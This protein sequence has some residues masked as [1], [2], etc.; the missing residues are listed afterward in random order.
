MRES[1]QGS[2]RVT[3]RLPRLIAVGFQGFGNVGDEA[4]LCGL[5]RLLDGAA[6][7]DT[8]VAGTVGPVW[9]AKG[10]RRI[11]PWRLLPTPAA[12]RR[13]RRSDGLII[14]GGGLVNDYWPLVIPRYLAWVLAARLLGRPVVWAGIGVGPVRRRP[15][16]ILGGVAFALSS[17][18]IVRDRASEVA[19]H[20]LIPA[21]SVTMAADPAFAMRADPAA[22]RRGVGFIVRSP[23][24]GDESLLGALVEALASAAMALH[25]RGVPVDIL[26]MHPVEDSAISAAMEAALSEEARQ[27]VSVSQLPA[28]PH[29]AAMALDGYQTLVSMRLHGVIL[30]AVA[31][32][33]SV[34]IVYDAKVGAAAELL[35]LA[36]VAIPL[37]D[38]T[39]GRIAEGVAILARPE[40][41]A[42]AGRAPGGAARS[43]EGDPRHDR[44]DRRVSRRSRNNRVD[45]LFERAYNPDP[46]VQRE[47]AA[48]SD[49]GYDVR[50]LGWDRSGAMPPAAREGDVEIRRVGPV[51]RD[52]RGIAQLASLARAVAHYVPLIRARRPGILHAVDLPMLAAALVISPFVGRPLI[53]YDAFEIYAVMES[54]KYPRPLLRLIAAVERVLPRFADL[55][56]VVGGE[57]QAYFAERGVRSVVV[58]NWIDAPTGAPS[59]EEARESLGI[60]PSRLAILY[61]G[62]LD[63]SRDIDS[64]IRHAERV[65]GDLVLVAG[66]GVQEASVANAAA[67]LVN[68]RFLGFLPDPTTATVAADLLYYSL[69]PDHPYAAHAAPNNLYVAIAY[70]TPLVHRGQGEIGFL[71]ER[72][73]IGARFDDD[74]SLDAAI[75]SLRDPARRHQVAR[76]LSG[77]QATY[78]WTRA[79]TALLDAYPRPRASTGGPG[80]SNR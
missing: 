64:L 21:A 55:V 28:D 5:E 12:M 78:S 10:A 38:V 79:A 46:R 7:F 1:Q 60:E 80:G 16:R 25:A 3:P 34:P 65:P 71:A 67:R 11:H 41:I 66:R 58:G 27:V 70:A 15:W 45:I 53:I 75:D 26:T 49:A 30:G 6:T 22:A 13:I 74:A 54:H 51:S 43:G 9:G 56:I 19:A 31:G 29:A 17:A 62:G 33:P 37:R 69:V 44:E 8:I 2:A 36:D 48:L 59:R 40:R 77:L 18:V 68:V 20:A 47:S 72:V 76:V 4:I 14:S 42:R 50:I 63:P 35:G 52:G 39:A 24:P 61:A 73:D 23:A 57:R 32:V